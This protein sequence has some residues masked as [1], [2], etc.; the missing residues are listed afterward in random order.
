MTLKL[1]HTF[2]SDLE[3]DFR[4]SY[5]EQTSGVVRITMVLA[6][7]ILADY[8]IEAYRIK[9]YTGVWLPE[10]DALPKRKICAI[11]VKMSRWVSIHGFALNVNTNLNYFEHIVPCGIDDKGV[12]SMEKELGTKIPLQEVADVLAKSFE[13]CFDINLEN[14]TLEHLNNELKQGA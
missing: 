2:P 10:T 14:T 9:E 6:F 5:N 12:T 11:G 8:Q 13:Q 4:R 1:F 3:A 7:V